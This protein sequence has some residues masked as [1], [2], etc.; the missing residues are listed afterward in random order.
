MSDPLDFFYVPVALDTSVM[1]GISLVSAPYQV[2]IGL[3]ESGLVKVLVPEIALEEFRTRWRDRTK[4]HVSDGIRASKALADEETLPV[5]IRANA[6]EMSGQ[7]SYVDTENLSYT[8]L[9][10]YLSETGFRPYPLSFDQAKEAWKNYF[11]G[12][13]PSKKVKHRSD[14]P[15]AHI[16]SALKEMQSTE[17]R[18]LLF[19]SL[20]KAQLESASELSDVECFDS[21]EAL[22]KS[23]GLTPLVAKWQVDEKWKN[24]QE[25]L[26]FDEILSAVE[27]FVKSDGGDLLSWQEVHGSEIPDDNNSALIS[28]FGEPSNIDIQDVQDWGGGILRYSLSYE[29]ECLLSFHVYRADAFSVPDWVSVTMGDP[30]EDHYFDAEGYA[31]VAVDVDVTVRVNLNSEMPDAPLKI[32]DISFE[33]SS[34]ELSLADS[35]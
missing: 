2:L 15:D 23:E 17:K 35:E 7:L 21:L 22:I 33:L 25:S 30:E 27:S 18:K 9:E 1:H 19:V 8:F 31:N 32:D 24:L 5:H 13:L 3:V 11:L 6:A 10:E 12:N 16:I 14:I 26:N 34:L 29:S 20:D 4:G 28:M